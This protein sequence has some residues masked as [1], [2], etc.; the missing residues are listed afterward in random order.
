MCEAFAQ[1]DPNDTN[2]YTNNANKIAVELIVPRRH[3]YPNTGEG[4]ILEYYNIKTPFKIIELKSPDLINI[5]LGPF[6]NKILFWVQQFI[7]ARSSKKYLVDKEGIV[8]S[9]DPFVLSLI[10]ASRFKLFWEVHNF[11]NKINSRFYKKLLN[12]I[13]GLIVISEGLKEDF[14]KHYKGPILVAPDGVD[15]GEF[16][17]QENKIQ[18]REKFFN[19]HYDCYR[20]KKIA[21]YTGHLYPWK[22]AD[23]LI[24]VAENLKNINPNYLV[25]IIGGTEFDINNFGQ[26]LKIHPNIV[27]A[28][29]TKTNAKNEDY[30]I[31]MEGMFSHKKIDAV[32]KTA[33]CA[34]LTGNESETISVKYT[35]P[36][37]MFEYMASGCPI[38]AQD[39]PSFREV[40]N[41]NNSVFAK[42]GD[43]EDLANKIAWVFDDKNKELVEKIAEQA[44]EDVKNYTWQ[45]RAETIIKFLCSQS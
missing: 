40:L 21:V 38:V 4:S 1:S 37:K 18:L 25:W 5:N 39:L 29:R 17:C 43:A 12:K 31:V 10:D 11:P 13:N 3:R 26:K 44:K 19:F 28:I 32:L 14:K 42:A 7:F 30:S 16:N 15:L 36:L 23:I 27:Y 2:N 35:S 9:R 41:G 33:D 20:R 34:I 45:K 24:N 8:Y 22:G 6:F